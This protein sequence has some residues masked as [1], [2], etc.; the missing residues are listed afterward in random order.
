VTE[1]IGIAAPTVTPL[2][3]GIQNGT[4]ATRP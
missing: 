2:S 3:L 4:L 1:L